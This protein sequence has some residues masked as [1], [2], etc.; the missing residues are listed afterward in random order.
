[1]FTKGHEVYRPPDSSGQVGLVSQTASRLHGLKG[2]PL[3]PDMHMEKLVSDF[4]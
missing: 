1:M 3:R 4:I 2:H